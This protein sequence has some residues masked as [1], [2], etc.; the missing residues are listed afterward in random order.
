MRRS[1]TAAARTLTVL[2][3]LAA[4]AAGCNGSQQV[5]VVTQE[6][7]DS[8]PP[9]TATP[10]VAAETTSPDTEPEDTTVDTTAPGPTE[11]AIGQIAWTEFDDSIDEGRLLV[12]LDYDDPSAGTINLY[13]LRHNATDPDNRIGSLLVNPGGPGFGGSD[14]ALSASFIYGPEVVERFDIIGWDPRGTGL[15]EPAVDCIDEYDP[16]FAIDSSPDDD[17]ER[18][19]LI[20]AADTFIAGC[21]EQSADLLAHIG[22]ADSARDMDSI[23]AALG[24]DTISYFGFSYG[25]ELGAVWTTLFPD[26][27][28]A[29]VIDGAADVTAPYIEQNLQQAAGFETLFNEFLARCSADS[30]CPF[31]NGGDAGGAFD[32]LSAAIDDGSLTVTGRLPVTQGVLMT[33]VA[34]SMY[35][36]YS[37]PDLQQAL[38]DAQNGDGAGLFELY[39]SYYSV[40]NGIGQ[41]NALE[42]YFGINC[43]DDPG[44]SGVDDLL[45]READFAAA[46]PRLGRAWMAELLFCARWP[47]TSTET[48]TATGAGAGPI[49]VVGTTGDAATPLAGTRNTADALEDGRLI[50]VEAD[51]HT[52][53]GVNQCVIDAVDGYLIDPTTAPVDE[54]LCS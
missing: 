4:L 48:V 21:N 30:T 15:S 39:D 34:Q 18:L 42:A 19:V 27:V 20:G 47:V 17:A 24:E 33:A 49:V 54:L 45:T 14:L 32:A 29:A 12:P 44:S 41:N 28:R 37:W 11:P 3:V 9:T 7:L 25:S 38:A 6:E 5:T 50:V 26:T 22:T 43:F 2:A 36:E 23:R 35:G 16:F 1:A 8:A 51:Q 10:R 46:A 40:T 53:Y 52:G 13:M 31:H